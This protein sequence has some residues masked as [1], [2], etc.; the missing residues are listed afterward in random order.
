L[1]AVGALA[2][3]ALQQNPVDHVPGGHAIAA[4]PRRDGT[5][6][7]F[8]GSP[9]AHSNACWPKALPV[10]QSAIS[11][12]F[13]LDVARLRPH[14]ER[15]MTRAIPFVLAVLAACLSSATVRG[16]GSLPNRPVDPDKASKGF[17]FL[18]QLQLRAIMKRPDFDELYRAWD[19]E[20]AEKAR[21][22][23]PD[24]RRK[25]AY[26]RY[27]FVD[28]PYDNNGLPMGLV[29]D[30]KDN[31][32]YINCMLC[33]GGSIR[34][35]SY[36]GLPNQRL[37]FASFLEDLGILGLIQAGKKQNELPARPFPDSD[38]TG[39]TRGGS[40]VWM[41][42][43][44]LLERRDDDLNIIVKPTITPK[45]NFDTTPPPFWNVKKKFR[46]YHTGFA[47]FGPRPP[48]LAIL[49]D[50]KRDANS[51]TELESNFLDVTHWFDSVQAPKYTGRIDPA[52]AASGK[53]LFEQSCSH[54]H[55][56]YGATVKFP[57]ADVPIAVVK[58]DP[59]NHDG[60]ELL[61]NE[62]RTSWFNYLG[63]MDSLNSLQRKGYLAPPLD[64]I[65]ASAPYLHNG[66]VPTLY[67]ILHPDERPSI[68]KVTDYDDYDDT[69]M[70]LLVQELKEVPKS[71]MTASEK[72]R[73]FDAS[74][75]GQSNA[76]HR[77]SDD[78]TEQQRKE[79]LEY[80]KTL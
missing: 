61:I 2:R 58:T 22:A 76:G 18:R 14:R 8:G 25:L 53:G 24:Q 26:D 66:S 36:P 42:E 62:Y 50:K 72:R 41:K 79:L 31:S 56:T 1:R 69:R 28:A 67:H 23:T 6:L 20:D 16:D 43:L 74:V 77:F 68:W 15:E 73:Y 71:P 51:I 57:N 4:R 35:T 32:V 9:G 21:T 17:V 64:G 78:L 11:Q 27:G 33:H 37:D 52:L 60:K 7:I 47:S 46:L 55:G 75:F 19:G 80:L 29:L 5:L 59:V 38:A 70:G 3:L 49:Y 48:M 63:G 10:L 12:I 30:P 65:W 54:C 40:N 39:R 44:E 45:Q 34:R 13:A